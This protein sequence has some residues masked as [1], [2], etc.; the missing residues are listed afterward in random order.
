MNNFPYYKQTVIGSCGPA[1]L[2][3]LLKHQKPDR[4]FGKFHE[5]RAWFDAWL[6]PFGMTESY[7]LAKHALKY[8]LK[9]I[10]IKESQEFSI[11][12]PKSWK[13][14]SLL[15]PMLPYMKLTYKRIRKAALKNGVQEKNS[16]ITLSLIRELIDSNNYPILMVDQSKYAW[17]ESF[18]D[19]VLH[20]IVV[21]SHDS[22]GFIINDPD[23]GPDMKI[24][25]E[26]LEKAIDLSNFGTDRRLLILQP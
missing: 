18:P 20:W 24:T 25:N 2:M 13:L 10:V 14:A 16:T 23:I 19:G 12:L 8:G 9:P 17:D 26:E 15:K 6:V 21:T 5:F 11:S 4:K 3:M 22:N 7:G 1:C